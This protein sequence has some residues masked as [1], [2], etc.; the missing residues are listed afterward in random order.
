MT[1]IRQT[2][3]VTGRIAIINAP[4]VT[5]M[6]NGDIQA[7]YDLRAGRIK[8]GSDRMYATRTVAWV[9]VA[10]SACKSR[11]NLIDGEGRMNFLVNSAPQRKF[12]QLSATIALR[13]PRRKTPVLA[14]TWSNKLDFARPTRFRL[15]GRG[16]SLIGFFGRC[17]QQCLK[18]TGPR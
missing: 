5:A 13:G 15:C 4:A 1:R 6:P 17:L 11:L 9:N 2:R 16:S 14:S 8:A 7:A 18:T 10:A 12:D 3:N